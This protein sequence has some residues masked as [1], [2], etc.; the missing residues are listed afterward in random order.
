MTKFIKLFD[1][2]YNIRFIKSIELVVEDI[3]KTIKE[4]NKLLGIINYSSEKKEKIGTT[5]VY[6]IYY[7][8][9]SY[10]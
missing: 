5:F 4:N 1:I 2:Y 6:Y 8:L 3:Y 9:K 10:I 7:T